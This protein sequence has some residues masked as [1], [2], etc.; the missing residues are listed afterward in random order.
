VEKKSGEPLPSKE[1]THALPQPKKTATKTRGLTTTK[2][3]S[4]ANSDD[5][6]YEYY[7]NAIIE[8]DELMKEKVVELAKEKVEMPA[9][10]KEKVVELT[11]EKMTADPAINTDGEA[12]STKT[13]DTVKEDNDQLVLSLLHDLSHLANF[14]ADAIDK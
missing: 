4:K 1:T 8:L 3:P 5:Y 10:I 11:K 14:T 13:S 2:K 6:N 9:L 7:D 12:Q